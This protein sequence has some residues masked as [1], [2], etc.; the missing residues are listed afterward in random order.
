MEQTK[1]NHLLRRTL[2][3]LLIV[4]LPIA[5]MVAFILYYKQAHRPAAGA[6]QSALEP[7]TFGNAD[8][9]IFRGDSALTGRAAG[10]LPDTLILAWKFQTK[11]AVRSTP[12][13]AKGTAYVS[14][15]DNHLYAIDLGEGTEI[16]TFAADDELEASPLYHRGFIYIGSNSGTFYCIDSETGRQEW[17]FE[18]DGKIT[19]SAN[20]AVH[21]ETGRT[22][23]LFGCYDNHLYC[24][25]AETGQ[26]VFKHPAESYINGSV[27]VA[28]NAAV[29][30]SCD[31]NIYWVPI[32]DPN[33]AKTIEAGSYV[34]ANPAIDGGVIFAGSY[35]G[36][37]LAADINTQKTIWQFDE[38]KDAFFSSPA[39]DENIVVVGC[40]DKNV[41]CFDRTTGQKRWT[42]SAQESFDSSPVICGDKVAIGCDD[43]RL[44]LLD[45]KT[46]KDVFAYTLG[47]PVLSS[48]AIAR[49]RLI[50][51]C[52]NGTVYA[53]GE[54]K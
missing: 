29:F 42:Y 11:D 48:A 15:M 36:T 31:A 32:A 4:A 47:S 54:S 35:E 2:V 44:Y 28:D 46:G 41:Y 39:V 3:P 19:G 43:G 38:G 40:R 13:V 16:W 27:A 9:T 17:F 10:N 52:D 30:G 33:A 12:I 51:G 34:A 49:N 7:A 23:I 21:P 22:V 45:I 14:S 24:L 53:F 26:L 37:L 50:I 18:A 8:W 1:N 6:L 5:A 25:D 20:V